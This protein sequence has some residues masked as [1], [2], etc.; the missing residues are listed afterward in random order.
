MARRA[1]RKLDQFAHPDET[2]DFDS[3]IEAL[4]ACRMQV[5]LFQRVCGV[6]NPAYAHARGLIEQIEALALLT[7]VPDARHRVMNDETARGH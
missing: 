7:R 3:L 6:R 5:L 4:Q 2:F 1:R